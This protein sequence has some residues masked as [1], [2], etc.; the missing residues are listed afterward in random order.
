[1]SARRCYAT[2]AF[3]DEGG[4]NNNDDSDNDDDDNHDMVQTKPLRIKLLTNIM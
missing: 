4:Y 2:H 3:H 1:V